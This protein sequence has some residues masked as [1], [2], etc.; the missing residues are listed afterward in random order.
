[1]KIVLLDEAQR[2]FEAEE[3]WRREHR[4]GKELFVDEFART[5]EQRSVFAWCR[6]A[7]GRTP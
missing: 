1:V 4:N 6:E 7:L 3:E 5:R 2:Q